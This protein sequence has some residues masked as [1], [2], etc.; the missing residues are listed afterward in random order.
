MR[1][2]RPLPSP[3][4]TIAS[5]DRPWLLG[6][7]SGY[8][9]KSLL[10]I[11]ELALKR[12]P[13]VDVFDKEV[14]ICPSSLLYETSRDLSLVKIPSWPGIGPE[15]WLRWR[16]KKLRKGHKLISVGMGPEKALEDRFS[17]TRLER[18]PIFV[19]TLPEMEFEERSS[20]CRSEQLAM[21]GERVPE[22]SETLRTMETTLL[23]L[24]VMP[25]SLLE[26]G[27]SQG[28]AS[29]DVVHWLNF[30]PAGPSSNDPF[31]PVR[32]LVSSSPVTA[33][34]NKKKNTHNSRGLWAIE[35]MLL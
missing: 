7:G 15:S 34:M 25:S 24:Q 12:G 33:E 17:E 32:Q 29:I 27:L 20:V 21:D 10:P 9:N 18:L 3:I 6:S 14:G 4:P 2:R 11:N 31:K 23:L 8:P 35:I 22:R 1:L 28:C 5:T 26:E 30:F 13:P 19:G 16:S